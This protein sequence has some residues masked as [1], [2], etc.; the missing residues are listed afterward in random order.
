[1]L[2][3]TACHSITSNSHRKI[4]ES[5]IAD[6]SYETIPIDIVNDKSLKLFDSI[7]ESVEVVPLETTAAETS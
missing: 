2:S 3:L 5:Y 6:T 4:G 7:I 1:M